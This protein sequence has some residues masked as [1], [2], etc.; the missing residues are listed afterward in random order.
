MVPSHQ[1]VKR[2]RGS[3]D[4]LLKGSSCKWCQFTFTFTFTFTFQPPSHLPFHNLRHVCCQTQNG[5]ESWV[6][7]FCLHDFMHSILCKHVVKRHKRPLCSILGPHEPIAC[8][9]ADFLFCSSCST[10][11]V[12]CFVPVVSPEAGPVKGKMPCYTGNTAGLKLCVVKK[13]N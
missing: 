12:C 5:S 7:S 6:G 2:C 13:I 8:C 3:S 10:T 4:P 11:K 9:T 1:P